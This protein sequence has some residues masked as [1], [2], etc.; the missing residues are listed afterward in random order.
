VVSTLLPK[1]LR[2]SVPAAAVPLALDAL[3]AE[4]ELTD[5]AVTL[6]NWAISVSTS[7]ICVATNCA[8]VVFL[9][10]SSAD[11]SFSYFA[12]CLSSNVICDWLLDPLEVVAPTADTMAAPSK[13]DQ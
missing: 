13:S 3:A 2:V 7:V 1:T 8:A 6:L 10:V 5:D 12:S 9:L 4:L 11:N